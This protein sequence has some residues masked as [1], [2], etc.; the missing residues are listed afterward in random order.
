MLGGGWKRKKP[1]K[2]MNSYIWGRHH[3]ERLVYIISFHFY[4]ISAKGIFYLHLKDEETEILKTELARG[5]TEIY[6]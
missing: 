5:I 3:T 2:F 1:A 4:D 6:N